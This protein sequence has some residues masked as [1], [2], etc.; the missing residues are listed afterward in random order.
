MKKQITAALAAATLLTLASCGPKHDAEK[1]VKLQQKFTEAA[2][3][4]VKDGTLSESEIDELYGIQM[5]LIKL[6]H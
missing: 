3:E 5:K 4:A 2:N 1:A 6:K